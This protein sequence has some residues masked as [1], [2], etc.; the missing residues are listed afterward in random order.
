MTARPLA[1]RKDQASTAMCRFA[2]GETPIE[3]IAHPGPP[4][5]DEASTVYASFELDGQ[6]FVVRKAQHQAPAV[7]PLM[8]L[9]TN[10]ERDIVHAVAAG[11]RN[12]QIAHELRLSE[13]TVAAY[14]KQICYK[15]QVRNR[16]AIVT[17][18]MQLSSSGEDG[19]SASAAPQQL[20]QVMEGALKLGR[21]SGVH[22]AR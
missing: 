16:T 12:K 11:L 19:L 3:I 14:I 15:L 17:R 6:C 1:P 4:Q 20:R 10:R 7:S 9:L 13:Y 2:V 18:C 8:S 21:P 5:A 22:Q